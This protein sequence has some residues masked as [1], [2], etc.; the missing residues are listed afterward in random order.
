M[1]DS[2]HSEAYH[3]VCQANRRETTDAQ[4][5]QIENDAHRCSQKLIRCG[6]DISF[7]FQCTLRDQLRTA[8]S[9]SPSMRTWYFNQVNVYG[10]LV[11]ISR[12]YKLYTP[13]TAVLVW[14]AWISFRRG[15]GQ[16]KYELPN[17]HQEQ[18]SVRRGGFNNI[19]YGAREYDA[20][21]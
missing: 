14:Q 11:Y 9:G 17:C 10:S 4:P 13:I 5:R 8:L 18:R 15:Q 7:Q 3:M 1:H 19:P 20:T 2:T 21:L 16:Y 6:L 12:A